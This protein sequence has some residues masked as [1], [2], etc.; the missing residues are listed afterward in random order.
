MDLSRVPLFKAFAQRMDWLSTRQRLLAE[1]VAGATTPGFSPRDLKP[2]EIGR[3]PPPQS[4][5]RATHGAHFSDRD[6]GPGG[7]E[8]I[9]QKPMET[10][11]SGNAVQL[12]EELRKVA[13][14]TLDYQLATN[15]YRK[16]IAMIR[17]AL[18]LG[19]RG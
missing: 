19:G 1:N 17:T 9:R 18:G 7:P 16:Q 12:D 10:T 5:L 2:M 11:L 6:P 3:A 13:E 8:V 15:L 4:E 14:T